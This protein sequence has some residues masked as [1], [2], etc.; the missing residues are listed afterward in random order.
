LRL[1]KCRT[2]ASGRFFISSITFEWE[3][4]HGI[5]TERD[6]M[7]RQNVGG[8]VEPGDAYKWIVPTDVLLESEGD[9]PLQ[10]VAIH[11]RIG[12]V[13]RTAPGELR[14]VLDSAKKD[15]RA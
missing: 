14:T 9:Q 10:Y 7:G 11:D 4:N 2:A 5:S 15:R 12:G 3:P 13:H 8:K 1:L 6:F